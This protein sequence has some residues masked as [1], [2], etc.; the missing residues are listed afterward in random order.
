MKQNFLSVTLIAALLLAVSAC[1]KDD[2]K[3]SYDVPSTYTF[4][5]VYYENAA[6][7]LGMMKE[8]IDETKKANT[9]GTV[10]TAQRLL[11]LF[12]NENTPFAD[13]AYNTSGLQI[14]D[15]VRTDKLT[16]IESLFTD[17]ETQS[18]AGNVGA[19]GV[20]GVVGDGTA[21]RLLDA[22]GIEYKESIEK[23]LFGAFLYYQISEV[24]LS[25][26]NIGASAAKEVR[27]QNWDAA[28]G[29]YGVPTDFPANKNGLLFIGKYGDARDAAL[30]PGLNNTIMSA[31]L[32]GRAAIDND[33]NT[34]VG[35]QAV[36][37]KECVE[38]ALA[39]TAVNYLT[40][41]S[42]KFGDDVT[43]CHT[44]SE[45]RGLLAALSFSTT[46]KISDTQLTEIATTIGN[47]NWTITNAN[48]L[49]ART[50]L[51]AIYG[52]NP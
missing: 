1:S 4:D 36:I 47:S 32:K 27:Q 14:R 26:S 50:D 2:T 17:I 15:K 23:G 41:A 19:E 22:N 48:I 5:N 29:Y 42:T 6:T 44:L 45:F 8:L 39:A 7:R 18:S 21:A 52:L 11:N 31:F 12:K 20:A 24:L 37:V 51:A 38:K 34:E 9:L 16:T 13:A 3:K 49:K 33:D 43:R 35:K 10:V 25:P 46:K 40:I 30:V 28:F